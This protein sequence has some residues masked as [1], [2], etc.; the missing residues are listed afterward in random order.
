MTFN[1]KDFLKKCGRGSSKSAP[2]GS[3][4]S[5]PFVMSPPRALS[6]NIRGKGPVMGLPSKAA[7]SLSK[8][9]T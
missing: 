2:E 6:T 8:D 7:Q 5:K 9:E 4:P 1:M 3:S